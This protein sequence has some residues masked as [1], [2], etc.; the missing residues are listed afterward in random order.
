MSENNSQSKTPH[1]ATQRPLE[2]VR[3]L[4]RLLKIGNYY[5]PGHKTV[6]QATESFSTILKNLANTRRYVTIF[7]TDANFFIDNV[8]I[9]TPNKAKDEL[10]NILLDS[11]IE[12]IRFDRN[13][14]T[15][16]MLLFVRSLLRHH[17]HIKSV[18]QFT[19]GEL[20]KTPKSVKV[21]IKHFL[22]DETTVVD[23]YVKK[24]SEEELQEV[25]KKLEEEGLS[26]YQL[27][28]CKNLLEL[29]AKN[30]KIRPNQ[31]GFTPNFSWTDVQQL[32]VKVFTHSV[33]SKTNSADTIA[34]N[35]NV[36]TLA[37]ILGR[38][39]IDNENKRAQ[40]SLHL[41]I[42]MVK[43]RAFTITPK[44]QH[45][46]F[47]QRQADRAPSMSKQQLQKFINERKPNDTIL[48][49]ISHTDQAEILAI[50]FQL[51][52]HEQTDEVTEK[53]RAIL[54]KILSSALNKKEWISLISG[55]KQ[56]FDTGNFDRLDNILPLIA[57]KLRNS[58][59]TSSILF[60]NDLSKRLSKKAFVLLWPTLVNELLVVG[61]D[62]DKETYIKLAQKV[63]ALS[64]DEMQEH[65]RPLFALECFREN[66]I[67][68]NIFLVEEKETYRLFSFLLTTKLKKDLYKIILPILQKLPPDWL[69]RVTFPLLNHEDTHIQFVQLYLESAREIETPAILKQFAGRLLISQIPKIPEK[70]RKSPWVI[71]SIQSCGKLPVNGMEKMLTTIAKEKK[72]LLLHA[73]NVECR[74]A[75]LKALQQLNPE[76]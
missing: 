37:A 74:N 45:H 11:G 63:A 12:S 19:T 44:K 5:P 53:G 4:H 39:E 25:F 54:G 47:K 14:N 29:L 24:R 56:L 57:I 65:V 35:N 15:D 30:F 38:L 50:L 27:N 72:L 64:L 66:I 32:L 52:Q 23:N 46:K 20:D 17:S 31:K 16:D 49:K 70:K 61:A 10:H 69:G 48:S 9:K 43:R 67:A 36:S 8:P 62:H 71:R 40:E 18:K 55:I 60:F 33:D 51:M 7:I 1:L 21:T 3:A 6:N 68:P 75:A 34:H 26:E 73:W 58:K 41:L 59:H 42:S 76:Q 13:I 2:F 22:V 28:Q